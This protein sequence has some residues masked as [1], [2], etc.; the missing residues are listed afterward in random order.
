M[1]VVNF[2]LPRYIIPPDNDG[3]DRAAQPWRPVLLKS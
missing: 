1:G 2:E 3:L